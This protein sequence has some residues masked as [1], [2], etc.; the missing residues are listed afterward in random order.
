MRGDFLDLLA[1]LDWVKTLMDALSD[2]DPNNPDDRMFSEATRRRFGTHC[3][4]LILGFD[5][6]NTAHRVSFGLTGAA[7]VHQV[8][9]V[10]CS[11]D[12]RLLPR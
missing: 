3:L 5:H 7:K 12:L 9:F 1:V 10:A 2:Q 8:R 6:A 4:N 11:P